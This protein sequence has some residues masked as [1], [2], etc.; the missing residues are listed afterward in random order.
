MP[1]QIE[2]RRQVV[3]QAK[4]V[5]VKVGTRVITTDTGILDRDRIRCLAA[6]LCQIADTERQTLLVSS[7]AV[8]AGVAKLHLTER[9]SGLSQLQAVAAI[10]QT[11]LIQAY[12]AAFADHGRHAAQVLLT[13][14]DL[15]RRGGYLN[16]RNSLNQIHN[17]GAIAIVNENDSVAVS[18]LM[19]T[20]GDNDRLASQVAGLLSEALLIILSDVYGLYDG[21]PSSETSKRLDVVP[22]INSKILSMAQTHHSN[23]SRGGM[24]SKLQAAKIATSHGH[25]TIIAPGRDNHVL[26]KIMAGESVGTLF[27]PPKRAI[28]GRKRWIGSSAAI[29]GCIVI[30]N[31]AESA[32][33]KK[34]GSLLAIGI[35]ELRGSFTQ[36]SV[37]SILDRQ[38]RE[39]ARGLSNY[40]SSEIKKI[41]G[42]ASDQITEMLGHRPYE[43]VIH[44]DN[45]TLLNE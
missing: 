13:A 9:P 8:G 40:P 15:R 12:E 14:S 19:T 42:I 21:S 5:V 28:K 37:V 44:R 22:K 45:L 27:L 29:N 16:V 35:L 38:G 43:C 3:N 18:E 2:I 11:N 7:G 6:Q 25:P 17:F 39:I 32:I 34:G 41:K 36:G 1:P 31:G 23:Q 4:S 24:A 26:E 30:D 33:C 10:G 20:F